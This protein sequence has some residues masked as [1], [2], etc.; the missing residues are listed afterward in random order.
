[1]AAWT[2]SS[3]RSAI[4]RLTARCGRSDCH[5]GSTPTLPLSAKTSSDVSKRDRDDHLAAGE[6]SGFI[7]GQW[8]EVAHSPVILAL[9]NS[10]W[11]G[12][13]AA[14][15]SWTESGTQSFREVGTFRVDVALRKFPDS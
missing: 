11:H 12:T 13:C 14:C 9:V 3:T 7:A 15:F 5:L 2:R 10:G 8:R 4:I 6:L 1:M